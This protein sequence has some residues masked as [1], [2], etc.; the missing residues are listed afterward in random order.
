MD[1]SD[2]FVAFAVNYLQHHLVDAIYHVLG[3]TLHTCLHT[4]VVEHLTNYHAGLFRR[5]LSELVQA[6]NQIVSGVV[7]ESN[8]PQLSSSLARLHN[9][10]N[11][12]ACSSI[13]DFMKAICLI[14]LEIGLMTKAG[15]IRGFVETT[16]LST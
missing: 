8:V 15:P 13:R 14:A 7:F 3:V 11:T 12:F 2:N 16:T 1:H 4:G 9:Q 6:H 5:I 10:K